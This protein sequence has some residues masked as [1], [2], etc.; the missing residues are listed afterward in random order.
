MGHLPF[1][2]G[3]VEGWSGKEQNDTPYVPTKPG[4]SFSFSLLRWPPEQVS[5]TVYNET[6]S[7][8]DRQ[9]GEGS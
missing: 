4:C 2:G 6:R 8:I 3:V 9:S 5:E 7:S 1:D